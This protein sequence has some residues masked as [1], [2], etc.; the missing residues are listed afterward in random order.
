[1]ISSYFFLHS[2][3]KTLIFL[4]FTRLQY[5]QYILKWL[6]RWTFTFEAAILSVLD[7]W[8]K[9]LEMRLLIC[10]WKCLVFYLEITSTEKCQNAVKLVK[11]VFKMVQNIIKIDKICIN[12]LSFL[13]ILLKLGKWK[14]I[15]AAFFEMLPK[16]LKLR[17]IRLKYLKNGSK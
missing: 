5:F 8:S 13:E 1:M 11:K 15:V 7:Y 4:N 16:F 6:N 17:Q 3:Y 2:M 10:C 14:D 9:N 12:S